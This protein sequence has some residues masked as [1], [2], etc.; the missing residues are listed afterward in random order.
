MAKAPAPSTETGPQPDVLPEL[1]DD[2][3]VSASSDALLVDEVTDDEAPQ[4]SG[5]PPTRKDQRREDAVR[6]YRKLRN[7]A[8]QAETNDAETA[9]D[10]LGEEAGEES[11]APA[12][13]AA[14]P[15]TPVT[16]PDSDPDI[17]VKVHGEN[18]KMKQSELIAKA[19]IALASE[20][21]LEEV[22]ALRE[23]TRAL[24][25]RA[26]DPEHQPAGDDL[27]AQGD[28]SPDGTRTANQPK[29]ELDTEKLENIVER[30]Q[31]GDKE[32]GRQ[33]L[34]E[35]IELVGTG[36]QGDGLKPE[37]IGRVVNEQ[38]ARSRIVSEIEEAANGF[39]SKYDA[40]LKDQDIA[41]LSLA[42]LSSEVRQ[43]L[44][45]A[46]MAQD[47]AAKATP[48]QLLEMHTQARMRGLKVRPMREHFDKVG[49]DMSAKFGAVVGVNP[50]SNPTPTQPV[51]PTPSTRVAERVDRKRQASVQPRSA[52]VRASTEP[53]QKPK[54]RADVLMEMRRSRGFSA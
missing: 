34:T 26:T 41:E 40:L 36:K 51:T 1:D 48:E 18:R 9:D 24:R 32:E 49:T 14:A 8:A 19:Q 23:E 54:S 7:A 20:N 22:K 42:R 27:N 43:D 39:Q 12:P 4:R 53:A 3:D 15:A 46:G 25:G 33:A 37:E 38:I 44:V 21:I 2:V 47:T 30:I 17:E 5:P 31:I 13:V 6:L 50:A 28:P 11:Q 16:T 10:D 35:L 52:G 29:L 45:R